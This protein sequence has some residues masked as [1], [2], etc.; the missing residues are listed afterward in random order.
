[1]LIPNSY[2]SILIKRDLSRDVFLALL[3]HV[4]NLRILTARLHGLGLKVPDKYKQFEQELE[5]TSDLVKRSPDDLHK[6][7][8]E[9]HEFCQGIRL[10]RMSE[11]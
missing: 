8:I 9:V 4:C 10:S 1:M 7:L 3:E 5:I 11:N 2:S 6:G